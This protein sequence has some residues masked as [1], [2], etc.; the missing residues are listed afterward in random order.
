MGDQSCSNLELYECAA[1][2]SIVGASCSEECASGWCWLEEPAV[3]LLPIGLANVA[4]NLRS[5]LCVHERRVVVE[6]SPDV[7]MRQDRTN[8]SH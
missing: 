8:V 1:F 7:P 6:W 4:P 2:R 3:L 5:R